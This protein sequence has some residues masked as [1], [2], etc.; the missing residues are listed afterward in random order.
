[1][2]IDPYDPSIDPRREI[3]FRREEV[4]GLERWRPHGLNDR[5]RE[6]IRICGLD[7]PSLLTKYKSHV[8]EVVWPKVE[9]FLG[10]A[11][12]GIHHEIVGAWRTLM[13]GLFGEY[14]PFQALSRDATRVLVP[15]ALRARYQLTL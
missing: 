7:R 13:W 12:T 3:E 10:V 6:T 9:R 5:G 2:V 4:Q 8:R 1:M 14:Q 15:D 11:E